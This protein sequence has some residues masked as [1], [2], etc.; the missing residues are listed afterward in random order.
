[1]GM[2][3]RIKHKNKLTIKLPPC[4]FE[5]KTTP[6]PRDMNKKTPKFMSLSHVGERNNGSPS[7]FNLKGYNNYSLR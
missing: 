6:K 5:L 2:I 4:C 1:M 7:I 3:C